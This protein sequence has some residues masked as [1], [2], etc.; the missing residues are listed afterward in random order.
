MKDCAWAKAT[1]QS[2]KER[3]CQWISTGIWSLGDSEAGAGH[4][5]KAVQ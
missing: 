4:K 1:Q 5:D 3:A 2:Q